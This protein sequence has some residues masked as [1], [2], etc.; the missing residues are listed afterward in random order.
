MND[1]AVT[2]PYRDP[3]LELCADLIRERFEEQNRNIELMTER[4]ERLRQ[5]IEHLLQ[6]AQA[7]SPQLNAMI[8]F[9]ILTADLAPTRGPADPEA[10]PDSIHEMNLVGCSPMEGEIQHPEGHLDH[11]A[12]V[13][14]R[15]LDRPTDGE[16]RDATEG[17]NR[18]DSRS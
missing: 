16:P 1:A 9:T 13:P 6:N 5:R 17:H 12:I 18:P 4:I 14:P 8:E 7:L 15:Q 10:I 2:S 11:P 3:V